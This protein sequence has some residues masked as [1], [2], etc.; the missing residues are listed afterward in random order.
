MSWSVV[1]AV[2]SAISAAADKKLLDPEWSSLSDEAIAEILNDNTLGMIP[3]RMRELARQSAR[4][5]VP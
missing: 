5:I 3:D 4:A 2:I 1:D